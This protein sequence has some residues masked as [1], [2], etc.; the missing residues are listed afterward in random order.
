M[1]NRIGSV[2]LATLLVHLHFFICNVSE[3]VCD[4]SSAIISVFDILRVIVCVYFRV[5][6]ELYLDIK[7]ITIFICNIRFNELSFVR[8]H[9]PFQ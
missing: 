7:K 4:C 6:L 8:A 2:W 5:I 3:D 9:F 1:K